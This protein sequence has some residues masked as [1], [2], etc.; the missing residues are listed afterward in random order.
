MGSLVHTTLLRITVVHKN[1][2]Y[3]S[4]CFA[5]YFL[6][7]YNYKYVKSIKRYNFLGSAFGKT[8]FLQIFIFR[9]PFYFRAAG[10]FRRFCRRIYSPHFCGKKCPKRSSR[11]IPGKILQNLHNQ[12]PR[13]ISAEG[14][15]QNFCTFL[16]MPLFPWCKSINYNCL[17][18][19]LEKYFCCQVTITIATNYSSANYLRSS[20]VHRGARLAFLRRNILRRHIVIAI[21]FSGPSEPEIAK[22]VLKRV[23]LARGSDFQTLFDNQ[24]VLFTL[25][26]IFRDFSAALPRRPFLRLSFCDFGLG[27]PGDS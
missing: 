9:P 19:C 18:N 7:T 20:F 3:I 23:F 15:G 13:H 25:W 16:H 21:G 5:N 8:D 22:K 12:N 24:R 6:L 27:G 10:F 14:P 4:S 11:K 1:V 2:T 26:G 17:N